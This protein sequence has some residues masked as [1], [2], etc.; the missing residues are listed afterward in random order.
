MQYI[1]IPSSGEKIALKKLKG[2]LQKV[3]SFCRTNPAQPL[4][5][6]TVL[7]PYIS[8]GTL[9]VRLFHSQLKETLEK[10]SCIEAV[11]ALTYQLYQR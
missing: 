5:D 11:V 7:S 4:P 2:V 6:S 1:S 10:Y 3:E 9:S 8:L